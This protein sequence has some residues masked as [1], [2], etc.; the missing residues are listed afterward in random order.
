MALDFISSGAVPAASSQPSMTLGSIPADKRFTRRQLAKA[1][2]DCGLP[3]SEKTLSTKAS[4]GGGPPYQRYGKLAIYT[5]ESSVE[6]ALSEMGAPAR[7]A[8]ER[9]ATRGA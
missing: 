2:T 1:L 9:R 5:W 3:T 6:W 7:S 4:R 8:S